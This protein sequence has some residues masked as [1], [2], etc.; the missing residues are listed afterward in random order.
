MPPAFGEQITA[1][2]SSLGCPP[3]SSNNFWAIYV[4]L[5]NSFQALCLLPP[6]AE[7]LGMA[8]LGAEERLPPLSGL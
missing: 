8:D 4:E 7:A 1:F 3:V 2:Y 5:V 6:I